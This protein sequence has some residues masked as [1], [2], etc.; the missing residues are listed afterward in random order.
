MD[1][2]QDFDLAL[3]KKT[4]VKKNLQEGFVSYPT[5]LGILWK[6]KSEFTSKFMTELPQMFKPAMLR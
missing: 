5:A 4:R 2:L 6:L 1:A 3:G